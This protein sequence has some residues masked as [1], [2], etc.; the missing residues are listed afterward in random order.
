[1]RLNA[2]IETAT[3]GIITIDEKGIMELVNPA[4]ARLFGYE[5]EE[6]IGQNISLLMPEPYRSNHD[7]YMMNYMRTGVARIIGIGREVR[8]MKKDGSVFPIRLSIS[9]VNL[10]DRR[11]FTGIVH[12]LTEQKQAENALR[13]EKEKAQMYF[14]IASTINVVLDR[15]G[16]IQKINKKGCEIIGKSEEELLGRDWFDM[17][18]PPEYRKD[19]Q[20]VFKNL[21]NGNESLAE[22]FEN[23]VQTD[24]GE[25]RLIAWRNSLIRDKSNRITGVIS[26]GID[27]TERRAAEDRIIKLNAELE[28][29]VEQRTEELASAVNQLLNFNK[30]LEHEIKERK[31][32]EVVIKENQAKLKEAQK[33]AKL[34]YWE[35]NLA[36][37]LITWSE[38]LCKIFGVPEEQPP[39]N[40]EYFF[41]FV[42]S[43]DIKAV[44]AMMEQAREQGKAPPIEYR[45]VDAGGE[46]KWLHS[47][48][49]HFAADLS[50]RPVKVFGIVQDITEH[51][52]TQAQLRAALQKEKELSELKSR[53]V[54]MASHE[55]RTPLSTILSSADLIEAYTREDQQSKRE[56]HTARIKS[57]VANLTSILND[58][59]SLS[60]LEEGK[61]IVQPTE[62]DMQEFCMQIMDELQ[63]L[64]KPGQEIR[65]HGLGGSL[66]VC[67]DKKFLKNILF[68]LLSNAIK[69]SEKPIDCTVAVENNSLQIQIRDYGIGIPQEEQQHL[70]TRFFR[71]HN[72]E[73]IQGTGLGLNI[74]KRYVD[75]MKGS[76]TFESKLGEGS[77][78]NVTLPIE[79]PSS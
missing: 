14:D 45:I 39:V 55:F 37:N 54:S 53:F 7:D 21:I 67:T 16:K 59:L 52:I 34:G 17:A 65:H 20:S 11:I 49:E 75:I 41:D 4:A 28:E 70:F 63:G 57:A 69:Y 24:K 66:V 78:F 74:V 77:I 72:V 23:E 76:I 15:E 51:K 64:I 50:G 1:M 10:R 46:I 30:Q 35:W 47:S 8:G 6:L 31:S 42:H 40:P 26:S 32:A 29:R 33:L 5:L 25:E 61:L 13:H 2:I 60:R 79:K 62:F 36:P 22:Y 43:E 12:D 38:E 68:N 73:N 71:A 9:E 3:D 18:I 58:F 44:Q 56:R 27:I 48:G 19:L